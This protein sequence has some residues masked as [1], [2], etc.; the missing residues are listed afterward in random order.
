MLQ[1]DSIEMIVTT[2][3]RLHLFFQAMDSV[4]ENVTDVGLLNRITCCDDNSSE[5]DRR[6][7]KERYPDIEFIFRDGDK[8]QHVS[9]R[10]LYAREK[11]PHFTRCMN[12]INRHPEVTSVVLRRCNGEEHEDEFGKYYI[13]QY[14]PEERKRLY[15]EDKIDYGFDW[16]NGQ[17]IW[18]GWSTNS[19]VQ[20]VAPLK[21]I[22]YP[23]YQHEY[24]FA[25]AYHVAGYRVAYI[26]KW[27][28]RHIGVG[29]EPSAYDL[30]KAH[31]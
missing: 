12:I 31:R 29:D 11:G 15:E 20:L 4:F 2:C 13:K 7:M 1:H 27:L 25:E 8:G 3:K 19:N 5:E 23:D 10:Q 9:I 28:A 17:P 21:E 6:A 30:N 14:D 26:D 18:P 22:P 16:K 24:R